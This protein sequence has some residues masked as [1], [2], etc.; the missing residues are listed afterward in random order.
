M[1][2]AGC[3]ALP[4]SSF[5]AGWESDPAGGAAHEEG[6]PLPGPQPLLKC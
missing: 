1:A 4:I 5:G 2:M 3:A 6:E